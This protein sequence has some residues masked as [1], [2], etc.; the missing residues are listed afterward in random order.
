MDL[1]L[2]S[3]IQLITLTIFFKRSH[4]PFDIA[5]YSG[6]LIIRTPGDQAKRFELL[7]VPIIKSTNYQSSRYELS[8]VRIIKAASTNY[9][10]YLI[11]NSN[12]QQ[13]FT[14][15]IQIRFIKVKC[16]K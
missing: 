5:W 10:E 8:R 13:H 14:S 2:E 3:T 4:S 15:I 1:Q 9:Q 6:T 12:S 7:K 11:S 16:K